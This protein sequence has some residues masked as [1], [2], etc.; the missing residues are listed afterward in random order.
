MFFDM[1]NFDFSADFRIEINHLSETEKVVKSFYKTIQ[2]FDRLSQIRYFTLYKIII[3]HCSF[4]L[5]DIWPIK[6]LIYSN[7]YLWWIHY[8]HE[9]NSFKVLWQSFY[10]DNSVWRL[11]I[12][13]SPFYIYYG[14]RIWITRSSVLYSRKSNRNFK[15]G[16]ILVRFLANEMNLFYSALKHSMI[17]QTA[18]IKCLTECCSFPSS[19]LIYYF[20]E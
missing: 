3:V 4:P 12:V 17:I 14:R 5:P 20:I 1:L 10:S 2:R 8:R 11:K 13:I 9:T 19:I 15:I 7:V 6:M 18:A 16:K